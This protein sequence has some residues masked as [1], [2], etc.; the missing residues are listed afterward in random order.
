MLNGTVLR[1][2]LDK[3]KIS[4]TLAGRIKLNVPIGII[5]SIT[6]PEPPEAPDKD[7]VDPKVPPVL[8]PPIPGGMPVRVF[9]GPVQLIE[10]D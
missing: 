5:T 7:D 3:D 8:L 1:G 2:R 10:K 9:N 6:L 4:Y